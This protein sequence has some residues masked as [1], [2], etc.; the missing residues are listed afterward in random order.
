MSH[1]N[2]RFVFICSPYELAALL[3][4]IIFTSSYLLLKLS[5]LDPALV[6]LP[7]LTP[8]EPRPAGRSTVS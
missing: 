6:S 8:S 4:V 5:S 1:S 3:H 7:T 2:S